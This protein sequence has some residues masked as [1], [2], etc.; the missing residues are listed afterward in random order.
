MKEVQPPHSSPTAHLI[1]RQPWPIYLPSRRPVKPPPPTCFPRIPP[2][3]TPHAF[4]HAASF[5]EPHSAS[6]AYSPPTAHTS[7]EHHPCHPYFLLHSSSHNP[8]TPIKGDPIRHPKKKKKR[9]RRP[10]SHS[11]RLRPS[12]IALPLA[13]HPYSLLPTTFDRHPNLTPSF[14]GYP[15]RKPFATLCD[16]PRDSCENTGNPSSPTTGQ[17]N[18]ESGRPLHL[19]YNV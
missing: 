13:D 2:P 9:G 10:C 16:H 6:P 17:D 8:T 14:L 5:I 12:F 7:A 4:I 1:R 11:T 15:Y 3:S 19:V 18:I